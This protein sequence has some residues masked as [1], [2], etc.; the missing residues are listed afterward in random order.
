[1]KSMVSKIIYLFRLLK[2]SVTY[3][4]TVVKTVFANFLIFFFVNQIKMSKL[5]F[6]SFSKY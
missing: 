1:M 2:I 4:A 3:S 6:I 5:A